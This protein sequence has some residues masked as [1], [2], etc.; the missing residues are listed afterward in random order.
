[1]KNSYF[2]NDTAALS[3]FSHFVD[4]A[5]QK[6]F[7][8]EHLYRLGIGGYHPQVTVGILD[9]SSILRFNIRNNWLP[10]SRNFFDQNRPGQKADLN[11]ENIIESSTGYSYKFILFSLTDNEVYESAVIENAYYT[12]SKNEV[13]LIK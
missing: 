7:F 8:D 11:E 12:L 1:M 9:A 6:I 10:L 5:H 2:K 4:G 13:Q 3:T